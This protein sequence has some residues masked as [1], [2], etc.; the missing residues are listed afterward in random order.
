MKS[1]ERMFFLSGLGSIVYTDYTSKPNK[2]EEFVYV[3]AV[4]YMGVCQKEFL[5]SLYGI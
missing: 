1:N 3:E 2:A 5:L 4:C